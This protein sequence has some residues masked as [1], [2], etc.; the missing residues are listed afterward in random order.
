MRPFATRLAMLGFAACIFSPAYADE[1]RFRADMFDLD[2]RRSGLPNNGNMY[3][4]PTSFVNCC[5]YFQKYGMPNMLAGYSPSSHGEMTALIFLVGFLMGTHPQ[6]GTK[7]AWPAEFAWI[8]AH[9]S[10]LV[11]MG[12]WGPSSTWGYNSI[13][14]QFRA[15]ALVRIAYGRYANV[16]GTWFRTGGHS[17]TIGGFGIQGSQRYFLVTDPAQDDGDNTKQSPFIFQQ[18]DTQNFT[19]NTNDHGPITHARYTFWTG[20]NG[21]NRAMVD[22]MSAFMPVYAGW[23]APNLDGT[24]INIRFQYMPQDPTQGQFPSTYTVTTTDTI[25]D[26]CFD[27]SEFGICML[28]SAGQ[29]KMIDIATQ[30][31]T[32]VLT[33]AAARQVAVGG[34]DQDVYVLRAGAFFDSVTR[35]RRNGD[36]T[37]SINLPGKAAAIEV[38]D[39]T[40]GVVALDSDLEGISTFDADFTTLRREPLLR[41][42]PAKPDVRVATGEGL[43]AID[44]QSGNYMVSEPG[45][46]GWTVYVRQGNKRIGIPVKAKVTGGIQRLMAGPQNTVFVQTGG[47]RIM[48]Y[49]PNGT[50]KLTEFTN[51]V[52]AG[53]VRIP[54]TFTAVRA[55]EMTG[56]G[57]INVLPVG[58]NP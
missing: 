21:N 58:D 29:V 31:A 28:N 44:S 34:P 10:K 13:M 51:M 40:G 49:S 11:I 24:N 45:Q 22:S 4:V 33:S 43:F 5:A 50:L 12:A 8:D 48:T 56:P 41:I 19:L 16:N 7:K 39:Q 37:T 52:V 36:R 2:Q 53:T 14:N 54:K 57:W 23:P 27:P 17:V 55:G 3:C 38:D 1:F 32:T 9:T 26:W 47:N 46:Q 20:D 18:K 35:V 42:A 30:A 6:D 25:Q 15:G